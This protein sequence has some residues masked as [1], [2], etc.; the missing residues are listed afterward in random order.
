MRLFLGLSLSLAT[1]FGAAHAQRFDC[2]QLEANL[3]GALLDGFGA[4][5][6]EERVAL[7]ELLTEYDRNAD[8]QCPDLPSR[9]RI[10]MHRALSES[11]VREFASANQ[12]FDRAELALDQSE[13][14]DKERDEVFLTIFR[15][16]HDLNQ[17]SELRAI[18]ETTRLDEA[19]GQLAR[20]S[21]RGE[22][23]GSEVVAYVSSLPSYIR[24]S[25]LYTAGCSLS[26]EGDDRCASRF[27]AA[28][29]ISTAIGQIDQGT[30]ASL[31]RTVLPRYRVLESQIFLAR[32]D[33]QSAEA[34]IN[35]AIRGW[36]GTNLGR[37][38]LSARAYFLRGRI[39]IEWGLAEGRDSLVERGLDSYRQGIAI[40]EQSPGA[41]D[42]DIVWPFLKTAYDLAEDDPPRRDE[43]HGEMFRAVQIIR[44]TEASR[45]I[46]AAVTDYTVG[47]KENSGANRR[48]RAWQSAEDEVQSLRGELAFIE[49]T[50][51]EESDQAKIQTREIVEARREADRR[52][53]SF[54]RRDNDNLAERLQQPV[55]VREMTAELAKDPSDDAA[56]LVTASG[57]SNTGFV[58]L[59]DSEGMRVNE[60]ENPVRDSRRGRLPDLQRDINEL[61]RATRIEDPRYVN[62]FKVWIAH[63]IYERLYGG[64]AEGGRALESYPSVYTTSI[65]PMEELPLAMLITEDPQ[66]RRGSPSYRAIIERDDYTGFAWLGN[67]IAVTYLPAIPNFVA[68][69]RAGVGDPET[70]AL[71]AGGFVREE[72]YAA[73]LR[74]TVGDRPGCDRFV[75]AVTELD[76]LPDTEDH[77]AEVSAIVGNATV[78]SGAA[79]SNAALREMSRSKELESYGVIHLYTHGF[80]PPK[81]TCVADPFIV[82]TADAA[83][84]A[85]QEIPGF[86]TAPEIAKLD[87]NAQ[88]VFVSAC[89]SA[90]AQVDTFGAAGNQDARA[91]SLSG[92][93]RSF[94]Q[95][96]ARS[97]VVAHWTVY[98]QET[99][100]LVQSFYRY[101]RD[102][103]TT[104]AG[105]LQE[106]ANDVRSTPLTSHPIYWAGFV[107]VGAGGQVLELGTTGE[108]VSTAA[109]SNSEGPDLQ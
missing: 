18:I 28:D 107:A 30:F 35:E 13:Q 82:T 34:S 58:F 96:G 23:G 19:A 22:G 7:E 79:F 14:D 70:R 55:T 100:E 26:E 90:G 17:R 87:M 72:D 40:L 3:E 73:R 86:L 98:E 69:S 91:E 10:L 15:V 94:L 4:N 38:P 103:E 25:L 78:K 42:F 77:L 46:V 32:D 31:E 71:L 20:T 108:E 53:R 66:V 74:S 81:N 101:A 76:E 95:A 54:E 65:G 37:T 60:F 33:F 52:R 68:L 97:I 21:A 89:N 92:L 2:D 8:V 80:L 51:G 6:Y 99:R 50:F 48:Y 27:D 105:A 62:R 9:A 84:G 59:I 85:E 104:I 16:L 43:L 49:R 36:R 93:A 56:Y 88:L 83:D 64:F 41:M 5:Y 39:E 44:S 61:R 45:S 47:L 29:E 24:A 75:R 12:L 1:M 11:N 109:L 57:E 102:G 67:D 106:A 63:G